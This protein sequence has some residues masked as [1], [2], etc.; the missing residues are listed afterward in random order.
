MKTQNDF[1]RCFFFITNS[2]DYTA[3][4]EYDPLTT[5]CMHFL[6]VDQ[7]PSSFRQPHSVHSSPGSPELVMGRVHP[8]VGLDQRRWVTSPNPCLLMMYTY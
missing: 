3:R 7:L 8:W 5:R 2:T 1:S 4:T 6:P